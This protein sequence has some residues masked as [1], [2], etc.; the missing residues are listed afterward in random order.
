MT[1]KQEKIIK[2]IEK[3]TGGTFIGD[4]GMSTCMGWMRV[5]DEEGRE[6]T[7]DPNYKTSEINIAGTR[8][9]IVRVKWNAYIF[10]PEYYGKASYTDLWRDKEQLEP[11]LLA[12]VDLKPDYVKEYEE[13]H[14]KNDTVKFE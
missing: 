3:A 10:K 12:T 2:A 9:T 1:D 5:F 11:M 4:N 7:C 6:I 8:Y 13:R 14:K